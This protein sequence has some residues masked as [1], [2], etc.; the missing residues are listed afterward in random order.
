M[1]AGTG[2]VF[3]L[4]ALLVNTLRNRIGHIDLILGGAGAGFGRWARGFRCGAGRGVGALDHNLEMRNEGGN[5]AHCRED[6]SEHRPDGRYGERD[7]HEGMALLVF[8]DNASN[9]SFMDKIANLV[10]ELVRV[11]LEVFEELA[12]LFHVGSVTR[13]RFIA[14]RDGVPVWR[15]AETTGVF[16][17]RK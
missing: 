4:S 5:R 7:F 1:F 12:E 8:D 6:G 15:A 13:N 9:V 16:T 10:A 11:D 2:N 17:A 3:D 14:M